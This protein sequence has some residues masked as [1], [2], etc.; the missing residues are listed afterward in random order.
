[1]T[2]KYKKLLA[3]AYNVLSTK[4]GK[5]LHFVVAGDTNDL[6]L[7]SILSLDRRFV[8]VVQKWT[9]MD[10]PAILDLVMMTLSNFYQEPMCLDPLDSDPDKNGV[11]SD[12]K[13]VLIRPINTINNKSIR[14]SR[15]GQV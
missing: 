1:M 8:Q 7:D 2:V 9:R 14:H 3:D 13:I 12:H 11:K 4:Y 5:G 15:V 6:K 10:P